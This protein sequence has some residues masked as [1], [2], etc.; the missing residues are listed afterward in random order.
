MTQCQESARH[1]FLFLIQKLIKRMQFNL[2]KNQLNENSNL[3]LF[4]KWSKLRF[5]SFFQ[6]N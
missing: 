5:L 6:F 2:K 1:T 4:V 3:E